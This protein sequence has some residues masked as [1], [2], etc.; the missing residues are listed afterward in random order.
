MID[1]AR[2][3]GKRWCFRDGKL[4]VDGKHIVADAVQPAVHPITSMGPS[5]DYRSNVQ[6]IEPPH[7]A[8]TSYQPMEQ[9]MEQ[10]V[11]QSLE[12]FSQ[13]PNQQVAFQHP[14]PSY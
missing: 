12:Q 2:H 5:E 8:S 11:Q 14:H 10:P 3:E 4:Y 6:T 7:Q 9:P 1:K 13:T